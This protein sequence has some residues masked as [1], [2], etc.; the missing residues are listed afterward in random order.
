MLY[1]KKAISFIT[2]MQIIMKGL[3]QCYFPKI[4][5]RNHIKNCSS[6]IHKKGIRDILKSGR[7]TT[8]YMHS[9]A[10]IILRNKIMPV[11]NDDAIMY[12]G[13]II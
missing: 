11:L 2:L 3:L 6:N 9:A 1:E 10:N 13:M 5:I 4:T 12:D 8:G 7:G